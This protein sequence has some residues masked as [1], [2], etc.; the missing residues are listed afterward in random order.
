MTI[1]EDLSVMSTTGDDILCY[2][3]HHEFWFWC[4][5]KPQ[6]RCQN[7]VTKSERYKI[8]GCNIDTQN[9]TSAQKQASENTQSD[10]DKRGRLFGS[11][12]RPT[13][14]KRTRNALI[15]AAVPMCIIVLVIGSYILKRASLARKENGNRPFYSEVNT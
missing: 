11:Y 5:E 9:I 4:T 13:D 7:A 1:A 6:A 3:R 8:L 2:C 10:M 15:Y 12:R 14:W